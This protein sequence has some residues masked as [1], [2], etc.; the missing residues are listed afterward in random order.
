M[1]YGQLGCAWDI[2]LAWDSRVDQEMQGEKV[3][4]CGSESD[5]QDQKIF[6]TLKNHHLL[7]M[8]KTLGRLSNSLVAFGRDLSL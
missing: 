5:T 2:Y 8:D 3:D 7:K 1:V 6:R 4:L